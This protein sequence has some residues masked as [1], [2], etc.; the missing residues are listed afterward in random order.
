M[1]R[2][3]DAT[4]SQSRR[5][6]VMHSTVH[7]QRTLKLRNRIL[8]QRDVVYSSPVNIINFADNVVQST[9]AAY[10]SH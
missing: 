2:A 9:F 4:D 3:R 5:V 6:I 1:L 7:W 10:S 8:S